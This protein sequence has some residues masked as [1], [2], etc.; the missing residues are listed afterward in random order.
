MKY[1]RKFV[2]TLETWWDEVVNACIFKENNG[3]QEGINNEIK[4]I[5]R[6][7]FGYRNYTNFKYRILAQHNH[8]ASSQNSL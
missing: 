1:F 2:K 6:R 5:K 3:K 7:G 4:L 8:N